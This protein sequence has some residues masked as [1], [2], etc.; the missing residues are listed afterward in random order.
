MITCAEHASIPSLQLQLLNMETNYFPDFSCEEST[1]LSTVAY[2]NCYSYSGEELQC[3][4]Y[5]FVLDQLTPESEDISTG[6]II[7]GCVQHV[8]LGPNMSHITF[9]HCIA[10]WSQCR[11]CVYM[12]EWMD[13]E[14]T[15]LWT[16]I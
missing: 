16:D 12:Q 11:V 5:D 6:I 10:C 4:G 8:F 15:S 7:L 13:F 14:N 2:A 9:Y 1:Y 3:P